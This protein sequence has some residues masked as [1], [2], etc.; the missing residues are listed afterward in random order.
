MF[1]II[2]SNLPHLPFNIREM[3]V[4]SLDREHTTRNTGHP[5]VFDDRVCADSV[6]VDDLQPCA[7]TVENM[8]DFHIQRFP[9]SAVRRLRW[10]WHVGI[11][12]YHVNGSGA[13][14][15]SSGK[16]IPQMKSS[17]TSSLA[18]MYLKNPVLPCRP[19]SIHTSADIYSSES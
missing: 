7:V 8:Y 11:E 13:I 3:V 14:G 2:F 6:Y 9:H 17:R 4:E 18:F 5:A 15:F 19:R 10:C 16:N 1:Q 12:Q